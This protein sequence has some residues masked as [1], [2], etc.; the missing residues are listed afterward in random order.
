MYFSGKV[1]SDLSCFV[2]AVPHMVTEDD[3][4]DGFFIPKGL[5]EPH[6]SAMA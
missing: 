3:I 6:Y 2:V 5:H 4:F 1:R